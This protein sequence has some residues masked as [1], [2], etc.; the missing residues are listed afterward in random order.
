MA[1]RP[2]STTEELP[3]PEVHTD[4]SEY[5]KNIVDVLDNG[6]ELI[7]KPEQALRVM[8]VIDALFASQEAGHGLKCHI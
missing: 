8:K 5:Y 4:W 1:P 2:N 7:V 6:A 3:L